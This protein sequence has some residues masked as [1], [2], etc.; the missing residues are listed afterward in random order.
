MRNFTAYT[1]FPGAASGRGFAMQVLLILVVV[2]V[3]LVSVLAHSAEAQ[4]QR[5]GYIDSE[6]ILQ[7]IPEYEGVEQRLQQ[8]SQNW[9]D[10]INELDQEIS[11]LEEEFEAREILF[12]PEVRQERRQEIDNKKRERQRYVEQR[13]GP[14][15]DY[16]RQQ[17]ELLRPI[18]RQI[19]EAVGVVAERDGFDFVLD[20]SGDY[21]F[22]YARRQWNISVDVLLEMGIQ[23]DE[24]DIRR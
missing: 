11:Q 13:F 16:F 6:Y 24:E 22:F 5:I 12:T 7:Q 20:R 4:N 1:S 3:L 19:A 9:R 17:R 21:V 14:D 10:E 23:V 8:L 18:Q 2:P 15:G